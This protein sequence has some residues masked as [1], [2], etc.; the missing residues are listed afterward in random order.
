V[1]ALAP[2]RGGQ[3]FTGT[4]DPAAIVILAVVTVLYLWATVRVRRLQPRHPWPIGRTTAFLGGV[5]VTALSI[6]TFIGVY[7]SELFWVHMVQHL[8]LVMVAAPLFA[9][10]SPLALAWRAARGKARST[11]TRAL[12]SK[13]AQFLAHPIVAFGIYAVVIPLTHLTSFYNDTIEYPT[14]DNVEHWVYLVVGYLFWRQIFGVDPNRYRLH[15]GAQFLYLFLAIPIDTFTG[16][17]LDSAS[18]EMFPAYLAQHRTWGPSL[19]EDLHLGGVLMWVAGDTLMLWPMI[20]VALNWMHLEERRAVRF[21]RDADMFVT[22]EGRPGTA[23]GPYAVGD[24][25][26]GDAGGNGHATGGNGHGGSGTEGAADT[27]R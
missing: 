19:V 3:F 1:I 18:R 11:L 27:N 26:G 10:S 17:S 2:L 5:T 21:D 24:G 7:D 20:P 4:P 13:G 6:F 9:I 16:L 12:R 22:A 25:G 8:M 23:A 14:L 15:P